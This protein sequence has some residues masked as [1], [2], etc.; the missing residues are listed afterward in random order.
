MLRAQGCIFALAITGQGIA[1]KGASERSPACVVDSGGRGR[2]PTQRL[3]RRRWLRQGRAGPHHSGCLHLR[4]LAGARRRRV[5]SQRGQQGGGARQPG[6]GPLQAQALVLRGRPGAG[7]PGCQRAECWGR[8]HVAGAWS[9]L[10]VGRRRRR[11]AECGG[12]GA[13]RPSSLVRCAPATMR[14]VHPPLGQALPQQQLRS[15]G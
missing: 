6:R 12:C 2:H 13:F 7:P 5:S 1:T 8:H 10:G 11:L 15:D 14:A 4:R 3:A 9:D